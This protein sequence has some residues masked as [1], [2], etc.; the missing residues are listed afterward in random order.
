MSNPK[1]IHTCNDCIF[2]GQH[3]ND[4]TIIPEW[5]TVF[6]LYFHQGSNENHIIARYGNDG[7]DYHLD[8]LPPR[9]R[10]YVDKWYDTALE[11]IEKLQNEKIQRYD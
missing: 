3:Y 1:F 8:Y 6:D 7:S 10:L 11:L 4:W 5:L 9:K 2:L